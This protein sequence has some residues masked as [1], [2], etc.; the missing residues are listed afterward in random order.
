MPPAPQ[1]RKWCFTTFDETTRDNLDNKTTDDVS[2]P[3]LRYLVFQEETCPS[4]GRWHIQGYAEFKDPVRRNAL[5]Q[6]IGDRVCR[7]E[8]AN[9]TAEQNKAYCTKEDTRVPDTDP[10][11]IGA[12]G[13][14][15]QRND[16][17]GLQDAIRAGDPTA[18]LWEDHF[19]TMVRYHRA[20]DAYRM[21]QLPAEREPPEV[22]VY[23]GPTGT[24]K[25]RR[26]YC[27]TGGDHFTVDIPSLRGTPWFD[28]YDGQAAVLF[29]D[30]GGEYS[31]HYLKRLID[32]YPMNVQ[33]K[34][35][36]RR[37]TPKYIYIT[38]NQ[39]PDHW[40]PTARQVDVDAVKR[41]ITTVCHMSSPWTPP[42]DTLTS[43]Q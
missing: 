4:T 12:P 8:P 26:V 43:S 11:E 32:R 6:W 31:V 42:A 3:R 25:T 10:R 27:E 20:V 7:C 9:G 36:Y 29:D 23:W 41:R 16:L 30:Y 39:D 21:V 18:L 40:Y 38:S 17:E 14:Q 33:V 15:G 1:A 19:P 13:K 37:W 28:G 24:G 35:G 2:R 34:G 5:Q 22:T